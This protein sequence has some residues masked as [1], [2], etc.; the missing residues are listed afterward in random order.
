VDGDDL[1]DILLA[2]DGRPA[3]YLFRGSSL[4]SSSSRV[5]ALLDADIHLYGPGEYAPTE[6][7]GTSNDYYG[8]V[9]GP[10]S[11]AGDVDGDGLADITLGCG[12]NDNGGEDA[13]MAYVVLGST[14]GDYSVPNLILRDDGDFELFGEDV[15]QNAGSHVRNAGDVNG[16]GSDELIVGTWAGAKKGYLVFGTP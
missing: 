7:P 6:D 12:A 9:G 11:T 2:C 1:D 15:G 8:R 3:T 5:I 10:I 14:L 13:G 16:D 4:A